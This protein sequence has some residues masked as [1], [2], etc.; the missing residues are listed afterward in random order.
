VPASA[1][2]L[3]G[4]DGRALVLELE[5]GMVRPEAPLPVAGVYHAVDPSGR[6]LVAL[7]V[8]V[9]VEAARTEGQGRAAVEAW[10]G[11]AG[12]WTW[13]DPASPG[14]ELHVASSGSEISRWLLLFVAA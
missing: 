5:D 3:E 14:A 4:P 10:L 12:S 1:R 7:P 8:N 11:Q 9:D 13:M 6:A 2:R